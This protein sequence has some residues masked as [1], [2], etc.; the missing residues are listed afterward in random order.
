MSKWEDKHNEKYA[1]Y[2]NTVQKK[3]INIQDGLKI[4]NLDIG[5][6]KYI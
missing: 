1:I 4:N 3:R 6:T 5:E 2:K